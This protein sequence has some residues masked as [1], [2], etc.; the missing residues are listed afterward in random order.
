MHQG[1]FPSLDLGGAEFF[2]GLFRYSFLHRHAGQP[3]KDDLLK[4]P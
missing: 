4:N 3:R 1:W 2:V